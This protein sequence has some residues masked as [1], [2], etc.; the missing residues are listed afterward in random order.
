MLPR[1][2]QR[3][4]PPTCV[5]SRPR[6]PLLLVSLPVHQSSCLRTS[7]KGFPQSQQS[8]GHRHCVR[9]A[10]DDHDYVRRGCAHHRYLPPSKPLPTTLPFCRL[11]AVQT[12]DQPIAGLEIRPVS[13]LRPGGAHLG[14]RDRDRCDRDRHDRRDHR[15]RRHHRDRRVYRDHRAS[16]D[17]PPL[18]GYRRP[19]GR[20]AQLLE[21]SSQ[22][23]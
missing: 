22:P 11:T 9:H 23:G 13:R 6:P 4:L 21:A 17:F 7:P 19:H 3:L 8:R 14:S 18:V 12:V 20:R 2:L 15:D 5:P 1:A 10:H 16:R